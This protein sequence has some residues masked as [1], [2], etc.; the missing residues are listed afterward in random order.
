MND[1]KHIKW[2]SSNSIDKY[3]ETYSKIEYNRSNIEYNK[4]NKT[5]KK[6]STNTI[7]NT[8]PNVINKNKFNP[9]LYNF[10][11]PH[12]YLYHCYR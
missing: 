10:P 1:P 11:T 12:F 5:N 4:P 9:L 2:K 3:Y 7:Q 6:K 8:S